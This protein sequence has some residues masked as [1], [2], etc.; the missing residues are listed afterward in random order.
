[1]LDI[2]VIGGAN[3]DYVV[4]AHELPRP[5]DTV[6]GDSFQ[7]APG[8]KG[9]NQAVAAARLG[10]RTAFVGR[11]GSDP[12][13]T[14]LVAAIASEGVDVSRVVRC[15]EAATGV[16][17]I[18]VDSAGHKQIVTAPGANAKLSARDVLGAE[19][20]LSRVRVVL[21]Q[22]E[23]PLAA[24]EVAVR[25]AKAAGA[26]VVLDP[27]PPHELPDALL[28]GIDVIRP[29]AAEA[30]ALTGIEVKD[31]ASAAAAGR[32]LLE[33]G[34]GAAVIGAP[35][36]NLLVTAGAEKWFPELEV[37]AVDMT[38]SG[39]AMAAAIAV[40]LARGQALE[41]AVRFGSAAAAAASTRSGG[42]PSMPRRPEVERLLSRWGVPE[43]ARPA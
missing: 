29:N 16:A 6:M 4:K 34:V 1:M 36:G 11:L 13:G 41:Q 18:A 27:A 5:G 38:G 30:R 32:K 10:A 22:L 43:A 8:G 26:R 7:L 19:G 12:R 42:M 40:E 9:A 31:R 37:D 25:L 15:T 20:L 23:V 35:E 2:L 3:T 28:Q 33:R 39:D 24:V 21:L 17:L 14:D